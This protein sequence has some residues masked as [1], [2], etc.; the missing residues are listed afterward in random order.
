VLRHLL[1]DRFAFELSEMQKRD[2]TIAIVVSLL[3]KVCVN[4]HFYNLSIDLNRINGS[5]ELSKAFPMNQL[6]SHRHLHHFV[7]AG[8]HGR[9]RSRDNETG[10]NKLLELMRF[11]IFQ[12]FLFRSHE[13]RDGRASTT[14]YFIL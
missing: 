13:K 6:K 9:T 5:I 4:Q 10:N 14:A 12:A 2:G 3:F 7:T 11:L 1:L 8:F